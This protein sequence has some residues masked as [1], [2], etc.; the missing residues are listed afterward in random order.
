[1]YTENYIR[2]LQAE[3]LELVESRMTPVAV[4]YGYSESPLESK[5]KWRPLVLIIGNYSSGKST[6]IND[7]LGADIQATGQAPT[8]DAFTVLA[9]DES[10]LGQKPVRVTEQ[11]DGKYLLANREFPFEGMKRHGQ[12][13]AA[14]FCMKKVNSPF[15]KNLAIIDTPGMLDSITERDRGYNYQEVV[16]DLAHIADLVLVLFDP[17]KAGTVREAHISLRDTLPAHTFEDRVLFVLNRIDECASLND[18]LRVYGTLCWN[19]SQITGRKDIPPI[20]LTYSRRAAE[21]AISNGGKA[22]AEYLKF[23]DNQRD[24]IRDAVMQA[25]R[26]HLDHL[27]TFLE[28]HSERLSLFLESLISYR[29][30]RRKAMTRFTLTGIGIAILAGGASIIATAKGIPVLSP[31]VIYSVGGCCAALA[32]GAWMSV[33]RRYYM[34]R[35]HARQL[36]AAD[37][38]VPLDNQY[39]K[40]TWRSIKP[41]VL[42]YLKKTAGRF[43]MGQLR[44]DYRVIKDIEEFETSEIRE[45]LSEIESLEKNRELDPSQTYHE[46]LEKSRSSTSG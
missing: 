25:P 37:K 23:L 29:K 43:P 41:L 24:E 32:M 14:H 18:L 12:Q 22:A 28:T 16:G 15:L 5:I 4:N 19:L 42:N 27:A 33:V 1:M 30:K 26:R 21:K 45:A 46:F 10:A 35:F 38:L 40:E 36:E 6:L 3:L 34:A 7:F 39:R 17:H 2:S 8:D 9:C 11:K 44:S 20:R 31:P 13:F